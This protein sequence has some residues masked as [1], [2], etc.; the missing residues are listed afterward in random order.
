MFFFLTIKYR[1]KN[2]TP[3]PPSFHVDL[4][5][6]FNQSNKFWSKIAY[7]VFFILFISAK[8]QMNGGYIDGKKIYI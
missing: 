1:Q 5:I 7:N 8:D 6:D 4:I 3:F 2:S